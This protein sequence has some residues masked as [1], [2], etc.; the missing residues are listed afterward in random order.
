MSKPSVF[1]SHIT[2][3][4]EI[5]RHLKELIETKFLESVK[6]FASSHEESLPLGDDW[7]LAIKTSIT[8]C[9]LM[10]VIC[11]PISV[12]RPWVNF[13]A[14]AGWIRKI[15]VVPMCHSGMEPA[16]L[17]VPLNTLHAGMLS[18]QADVQ[19]LF[20]RL[21]T[22][23]DM[24]CPEAEDAEFFARVRSFETS[25]RSNVLLKDSQ[26][27]ANLLNRHIEVLEFC[28]YASTQDY[29]FLN[30]LNLSQSRLENYE[31]T[32]NNVHHLFN[33]SLLFW[34]INQKVYELIQ[35]T[36]LRITDT[37][38][39]ILANSHLGIAPELEERLYDFLY[40]LGLMDEWADGIGMLD[41]SS[42]NEAPF[43]QWIIDTI[44]E[45]P[46]PAKREGS[47]IMDIFV[48]YYENL[49]F[50]KQWIIDYKAIT[51]RLTTAS[52]TRQ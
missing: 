25:I 32:F 41:R 38:R 13:E 14:G 47:H 40:G 30:A 2:E 31:F 48:A 8:N 46:L 50:Y 15:P 17:P 18:I 5:A 21:A 6:V 7:L 4:G 28:I 11:S 34:N 24:K 36:V 19:K 35:S 9:G 20:G 51:G 49:L 1:I 29:E 27:I 26:F 39:F 33:M 3:E 43:R 12:A 52:L 45:K 37:I 22:I 10:V 16:R 42:L 23:A 44:K